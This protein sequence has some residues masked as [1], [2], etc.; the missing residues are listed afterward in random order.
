LKVKAVFPFRVTSSDIFAFD[1]LLLSFNE[2]Y[3]EQILLLI[4]CKTMLLLI[5]MEIFRLR[6]FTTLLS[7]SLRPQPFDSIPVHNFNLGIRKIPD[8]ESTT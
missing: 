8:G 7:Q 6:Q 2:E 1:L 5:L 4:R 3:V